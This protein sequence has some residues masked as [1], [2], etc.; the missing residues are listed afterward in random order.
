[1]KDEAVMKEEFI[2]EPETERR[3]RVAYFLALRG[4]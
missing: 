3:P 2:L 4:C 1:M